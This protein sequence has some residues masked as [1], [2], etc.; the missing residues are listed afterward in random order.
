MNKLFSPLL[1][2]CWGYSEVNSEAT[3]QVKA[4]S[5]LLGR[6]CIATP[7]SPF[8][9]EHLCRLGTVLE[10]G[11]NAIKVEWVDRVGWRTIAWCPKDWV[12]IFQVDTLSG[13]CYLIDRGLLYGL[14]LP[15]N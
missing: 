8:K 5:E 15:R 14:A 3:G 7:A 4:V 10:V 1:T 12:H 9:E 11:S 6:H 2:A 13:F